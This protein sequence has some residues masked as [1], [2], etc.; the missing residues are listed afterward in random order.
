M[1]SLQVFA[2]LAGAFVLGACKAPETTSRLDSG[3]FPIAISATRDL[4][5]PAQSLAVVAMKDML[6][7]GETLEFTP[8]AMQVLASYGN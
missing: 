3:T 5:E 8:R 2:A 1:K 6:A 4:R 7:P